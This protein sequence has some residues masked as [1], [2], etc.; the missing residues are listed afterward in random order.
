MNGGPALRTQYLWSG[1]ILAIAAGVWLA[2]LPQAW[3]WVGL[4]DPRAGAVVASR[5]TD[6]VRVV[7]AEPLAEPLVEHIAAIGTVRA[8]RSATI[9]TE[10]VGRLAVIA[11]SP[12]SRVEEGTLVAALEDKAAVIALERARLGADDARRTLDRLERL[13]VSGS[14]TDTALQEAASALTS[15][16][17][18][19]RD[20]ELDLARHR[21]LAPI[22]GEI[23][24]IAPRVG[25]YLAQGAAIAVIEDRADLLVEFRLPDS[26]IAGLG[27][28]SRFDVGL[29]AGGA[30]I[31]EARLRATDNRV[32]AL[33]RTLAV[34]ATIEK[35]PPELRSGMAVRLGFDR[36]GPA[37]PSVDPQAIQW[38]SSGSFVW[39]LRDGKAERLPVRIVQRRVDRVLVEAAVRPGDLVVSEGVLSLRP[40]IAA[41]PVKASATPPSGEGADG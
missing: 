34:E 29:L 23:G 13:Q 20:A 24:L 17:L 32:D 19:V 26:Q 37:F 21:I 12:G 40:G 30:P 3:D 7:A 16:V 10:I 1:A 11:V 5:P 38:D 25:D 18:E 14:V 35:P 9:S 31:T 36:T 2:W 33:S 28:G 15:A 27:P 39:L 8:S 6:P 22:S 41:E 4:A